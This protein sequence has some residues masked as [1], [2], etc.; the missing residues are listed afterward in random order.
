MVMKNWEPL[1]S[2]PAC[3][4]GQKK[5]QMQGP[6]CGPEMQAR[7]RL[8]CLHGF[9]QAAHVGHGQVAGALVLELEVLVLHGTE[10]GVKGEGMAQG[11]AM[12]ALR[13]EAGE[14]GRNWAG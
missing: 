6:Q 14:R 10:R 8:G 1:V 7:L 11:A 5:A 12:A 3:R 2:G 4:C 9:C 13:C